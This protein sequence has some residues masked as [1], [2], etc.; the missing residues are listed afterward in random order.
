[1][2]RVITIGGLHGTGKSSVAD[3][4]AQVASSCDAGSIVVLAIS[5]PIPNTPFAVRQNLPASF[6]DSLKTA[7]L[8]V[9][10]QPDVIKGIGE[11]YVDPTAD[12]KLDKLD[13]FY[14]PL[15]TVA[16]VLNLDLKKLAG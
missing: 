8:N 11:W 12:P 10:N 7:L 15:R 6:K 3:E 1:M 9:K 5:D 2:K 13:S 4:I 16:K 14:D